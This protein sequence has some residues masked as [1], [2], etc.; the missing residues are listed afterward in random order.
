MKEKEFI[1][2]LYAEKSKND[3][4]SKSLAGLLNILTQTV[5][6]DANRF[7][8]E[9]IQNADDSP[10][11]TGAA[12]VEIE[13]KLLNNYLIFSHT[14]KHFSE[15]DVKGISDVGS[16]D[17]GKTK[18]IEKTGYK[19]IGFKSI[20]G[21]SDQV[22]ILSNKF[23]FKFDK[24][25][26][27]WNGSK[28]YPWQIIPIWFE[29][30]ELLNELKTELN[31]SNVITVISISDN[32]RIKQEVL[33]VLNDS[34][35]M[36]FLRHIKKITFIDSGIK[37]LELNREPASSNSSNM[38]SLFVN[39]Q[40]KSNWLYKEFV[41][42]VDKDTR[43]KIKSLDPATCPEKLRRATST[44]ITFAALIVN[45]IIQ[46]LSDD[47]IY[48]YLPT[49][50]K[51]NF[52][53]LINGDFITNAER[54][55]ILDNDWN[56]FI[57]E[58]IA[59][60]KI[61]WLAELANQNNFKYEFSK[62]IKHK[63]PPTS[64]LILKS[65]NSGLD[66]AIAKIPFIPI[67]GDE[68][69]L[70]KIN[71]CILDYTGFSDVFGTETLEKY[72]NNKL[73]VADC[74]IQNKARLATLGAKKF[75]IEDL[76]EFFSTDLFKLTFK[77][78]IDL[79][80]RLIDFLYRQGSNDQVIDWVKHLKTATFMLTEGDHLESPENLY[81]PLADGKEE[82]TKIID[83]NFINSQI[84]ENI[85]NNSEIVKW[86]GALGVKEPSEVD[87]LR[88]S[89]MRMIEADKLN[90]EN[91]FQIG[92]FIFSIYQ[93]GKLEDNDY[94][95]LYKL[96]IFN[97]RGQLELPNKCYLPNYYEPD[98]KIE[99]IFP[100][101]NYVS[102]KYV[103]HETEIPKW[104]RFFTRLGVKENIGLKIEESIE[105][106]TLERKYP[107]VQ[108]YLQYIDNKGVFY[109][110]ITRPYIYQ[111]QHGFRNFM[112]IEYIEYCSNYK[113]S[114]SF[115]KLILENHWKKIQSNSAE[116]IYY[117]RLESK[118]VTSFFQYYVASYP[119]IPS[120]QGICHKSNELYSGSLKRV[121]KNLSPVV[122]ED[123][124][125]SRDQEEYLGI[126]T[127]IT[128]EDCF[129]LLKNL[130]ENSI[131]NDTFKQIESIY[132]QLIKN[133][134]S[135]N[136]IDRDTVIKGLK[137]LSTNDT[138]QSVSSLYFFGVKGL[139]PPTNSCY[140]IKISEVLKGK[141]NL[142]TLFEIPIVQSDDLQLKT[143]GA[144][145]D[146]ELKNILYEKAK[147][148]AT[149]IAS[150]KAEDPRIT[151]NKIIRKINKTKFY[152]T[153]SLSLV[154]NNKSGKEIYN[155]NIDSWFE[156]ETN[157]IYYSGSLSSPLT[158]YNLSN[159]LSSF[160]ELDGSDRDREVALLLQLS[161]DETIRW[162][163][164]KGYEVVESMVCEVIDDISTYEIIYP[165]PD[166]DI[167]RF[168]RGE[169]Q[170]LE[171]FLEQ[172]DLVL[173]E[174]NPQ[175]SFVS[176]QVQINSKKTNYRSNSGDISEQDKEGNFNDEENFIGS[177][178]YDEKLSRNN[179]KSRLL[180]YVSNESGEDLKKFTGKSNQRLQLK[181]RE[182]VLSYE[183]K[184]GRNPVELPEMQ[185]SYDIIACNNDTKE[186][187]RYIR[188]Y[189][190]FGEWSTND[191]ALL[192]TAQLKMAKSS[193][194]FW[195]YVVEYAGDEEN[196]RIYRIQNPF[197]KITKY[198]FDYGWKS[199]AEQDS[200]V[201]RFV[202]GV[203]IIHKTFGEGIINA[204]IKKGKIKLLV[205][206]F[207]DGEKRI[208]LNL[209]QIKI[210]EG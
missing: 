21:T 41:V 173:N 143:N 148:F 38:R 88:R 151:L 163:N 44:K 196:Y 39:G 12:N 146:Q 116:A 205:V 102:D 189:G 46:D 17:S 158:L 19:G 114:L 50:V 136:L 159:S 79:S 185:E 206:N 58:Q 155:Q 1:K 53:F 103:E 73:K 7:V 72:C 3:S 141:E 93:K 63:F 171:L 180:S 20:F 4:N 187:E 61:N 204:E 51:L 2:M 172:G 132:R 176:E 5:F 191:V 167:I 80:L 184:V 27:E 15:E 118:A 109:N 110:S 192:S 98:L 76:R 82:I 59:I 101:G 56:G 67:Q 105:R 131:D 22:H 135:T 75:N 49:K 119:C 195:I 77:S 137:L 52:N 55:Q 130:E 60:C 144:L 16:G 133:E 201:D 168:E 48:C 35:V 169:D 91:V 24:N 69:R 29:E 68:E 200:T 210:M 11:E 208:P 26:S 199:I 89:I 23:T 162:L 194:R 140:F 198:A 165:S 71:D 99:E 45:D 134:P 107:I 186:V 84:Y 179:K 100:E 175:Y 127:L 190:F 170:E 62:L 86:L 8:F 120:N 83:L 188:V 28:E 108:S 90:K 147:Y 111:K 164:S 64:S 142:L 166:E 42:P 43:E 174:S 40:L 149:I 104:K 113:F 115:W 126:R 95:G 161:D 150:F 54:T 47:L 10:R 87:I 183:K 34:R 36:L 123:I 78:S 31:T 117:T 74:N 153:Q 121:I 66:E 33:A 124:Q 177:S 202:A 9:L 197:E 81:F 152:K 13:L 182:I 209:T 6:G 156:S 138:F 106:L 32:E 157:S 94:R 37:V 122:H 145:S 18:N 160:F 203:K 178:E 154:F 193:N 125:F 70:L 96:K 25:H 207:Q 30:S 14:G 181:A 139:L 85:K 128:I 129:K 97:N 57:F 92:R 65:F 112:L